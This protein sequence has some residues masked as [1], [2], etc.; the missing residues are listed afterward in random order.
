MINNCSSNKYNIEINDVIIMLK[1]SEEVAKYNYVKRGKREV[2]KKYETY[3]YNNK[4]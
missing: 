3:F 1:I 2:R 4:G